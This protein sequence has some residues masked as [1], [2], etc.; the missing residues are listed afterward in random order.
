M[1]LSQIRSNRVQ[2]GR[3][4]GSTIAV[5]GLLS[6]GIFIYQALEAM[7]LPALPLVRT[8]L[9]AST[10]DI[11]WA[12]TSVLLAGAVATPVVGRLADIRDKRRILLAALAIT[13]LGTLLSALAPSLAVLI[14]GQ[15]LQGVGLGVV[16][17]S[18]GIIRDTQTPEW[19]RIGN[20]LIIGVAGAGFVAGTLLA[21]PIAQH[22]SF[23]WLFWIPLLALLL[24]LVGV[25]LF[26]PACPPMSERSKGDRVG[27]GFLD[28]GLLGGGLAI[29]LSAFTIAPNDGWTSNRF[30][31][32][33]G[34]ALVLLAA[35]V[36]VELRTA[37]PL[38]DLRRL[39]SRP[40][41]LACVMSFV[42][43]FA[44]F[45]VLLALPMIVELPPATGYGLGKTV[46]VAGVLLVPLGVAAAIAGPLT[47]RLERLLGQR[48]VMAL[49]MIVLSASSLV[50]FAGRGIW[51]LALASLLTGIGQGLGLTA[52]MNML[53]KSVPSEHT[54]A[55]SG[56]A[57]VLKAVGSVLGAQI[58]ASVLAAHLD[59]GTQA[60]TWNG[61]EAV[62]WISASLGFAGLV[63][64]FLFYRPADRL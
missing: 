40:V 63:L 1:A 32:F 33:L 24:T 7:L 55:V 23:K 58:A 52:V 45:A 8:S 53:V 41:M 25:W 5:L 14:I 50:M 56:L 47:G 31:V 60:P 13:A 48:G 9:H 6:A 43:G 21:G 64:S 44:S 42:I 34:G 49:T 11:A 27:F 37:A 57:F 62:Y 19:S 39:A 15:A 54:G 2:P 10:Q 16:P 46:T 22:L 38:I 18:I 3:P 29:L 20:G 61:F 12:I 17:L 26:M 28:A 4:A 30:L 36:A 59:P 51:A 35:F